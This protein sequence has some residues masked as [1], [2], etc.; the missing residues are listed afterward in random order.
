MRKKIFVASF[1]AASLSAAMAVP[2]FAGWVQDGDGWLYQYS[3]GTF[4]GQGWF[5]DP[6]TGLI[7]HLAPGGYMM[8]DTE[9]EGYKL[10]ADGHR[11]DKTDEQLAREARA[12]EKKASKPTPNKAKLAID[13]A[14]AEA[15][16][17]TYASSTLRT[18]Y[19]AEM[20]VFMDKYFLEMSNELYKDIKERRAKVIEE[21][22]AAAEAASLAS[23]D[24]SETGDMS[25]D[26][27]NMY[28]T[29]TYSGNDNEAVKYSIFRNEDK[30]DI[31]SAYYS[32]IVKQ[33]S[34]NYVPY[35]FE[36]AYNRGIAPSE[37]DRDIFDK[38]Y[39]KMLVASLGETKGNE[40]CELALAGTLEDGH[41]DTTDAGNSFV[42]MNKNGVLTIRVTCSEKVEA[43]P[44]DGQDAEGTTES[45]EASDTQGEAQEPAEEAAS[46]TSSVITSG[47][48]KSDEA[49]GEQEE[50]QDETQEAQA[51]GEAEEGTAGEAAAE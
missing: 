29:D 9:V 51:E 14:V 27:S 47:Q 43:E 19:Q 11:L 46:T 38:G 10:A 45:T 44:T 23:E 7:Y 37:E 15:K 26:Y 16:T 31:I 25:I 40:V 5:T 2:S 35:T 6:D 30:Q 42:V 39:R 24:G 34:N 33:D 21:A 3:N 22:K 32:K 50:A 8:S 1:I 49:Q 36:L 12:A 41:T 18:H 20:K 48:K 13:A 4:A 17:K 28:P